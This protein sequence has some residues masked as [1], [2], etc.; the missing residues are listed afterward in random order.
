MTRFFAKIRLDARISL[1]LL[2]VSIYLYTVAGK[3]P[4]KAALFPNILLLATIV[5]CVMVIIQSM[6]KAETGKSAAK[7]RSGKQQPVVWAI[8][9]YLMIAL[10]FVALEPLGFMLSTMI[11]TAAAMAYLGERNWLVI[12]SAGIGLNVFVYLAFNRFL[13]VPLPMLPAFFS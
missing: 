7:K 5:L 10:Y 4:A 6:R 2:L 9:V 8:V 3:F 12:L 11:F 13:D 1:V